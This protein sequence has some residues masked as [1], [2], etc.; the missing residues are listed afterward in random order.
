MSASGEASKIAPL[1]VGAG[2]MDFQRA[3]LRRGRIENERNR[4]GD[5]PLGAI[6]DR[7]GRTRAP[8]SAR[9]APADFRFDG[10]GVRTRRP[11]RLNV[12]DVKANV[13]GEA[14]SPQSPRSLKPG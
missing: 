12:G 11:R 6:A 14:L 7:A 9:A 10:A 3:E 5:K 1:R 2:E 13:K 4:I 8:G